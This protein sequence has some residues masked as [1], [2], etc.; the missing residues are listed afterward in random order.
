MMPLM[1]NRTPFSDGV[2][3]FDKELFTYLNGF[4]NEKWDWF[5]LLVTEQKNWLPLFLLLFY[6]L[7]KYFGFK[8][9]LVLIV[10]IALFITFSDQLV[11]LIKHYY[12]RLRPCSDPDLELSIRAVLQ[13]SSYSFVSG[14]AT[15]SFAMST[16]FI[17]LLKNNFKYI[18]FLLIWPILFAYSRVYLGVHFPL[19]IFTGMYIG[20]IEGFLFYNLTKLIFNTKWIAKITQ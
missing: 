18:R 6:L 7:Y 2:V 13:R 11:N 17:L 5:W 8:K 15:T 4:G 16:F 1:I 14:H 3:A 9:G 19:D 10:L 20:I 12:M